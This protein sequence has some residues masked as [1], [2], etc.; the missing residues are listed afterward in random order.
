[1][2]YRRSK[3]RREFET[4][5]QD[6]CSELATLHNGP[7]FS[8]ISGSRLLGAYYV[9][10]FAQLEVYVKTVVEDAVQALKKAS[11]PLNKLPEPLLG[12]LL[13]RAEEIS[14][15]YRRFATTEDEGAL[16]DKLGKT[17]VKLSGWGGAGVI[18]VPDA[19]LFLEKRKYPSPKNMPQL[20]R[21]LGIQKLWAK[22]SAAGHF[23]SEL[24]LTSLNDLRTAIAHDG[25]VP[26]GFGLQ[27]FR[28][29]IRQMDK[30]VAALDRSIA[31]HF[32]SG[33]MKRAFW[34]VEVT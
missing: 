33:P 22:V 25:Q 15:G 13:H 4:Q 11:P 31:E 21:R 16:I 17:A 29:R 32:C 30:F 20:F 9:F 1:M 14:V 7:I 27:D 12:Y 8:V 3:A 23:N 18:I 28:D 5:I 10:A 34:N 6:A 2:T 19:S 24:T 26:A